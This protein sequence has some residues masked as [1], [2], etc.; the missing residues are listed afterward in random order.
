MSEARPLQGPVKPPA[1][2]AAAEMLVILLHGLGADGNDLLG[3]AP[4]W[5]PRL[6]NAEF[7]SPHAPEPCDMAPYGRQWFS[8]TSRTAEAILAG[9]ER[10]A[11]ILNEFIDYELARLGLGND[12]LALVG[13]SQGTMMSLYAG[14]RRDRPPAAIIGF[15]GSL[16]AP[17]RLAAEISVRPPVLLVH[18]DADEVVPVESLHDAVAGL[19]SAGVGVI[20]HVCA[21]MGHQIDRTGLDMGGEF[22]AAHLLGPGYDIHLSALAGAA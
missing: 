14:L 19:S 21:G 13:F 5:A 9:A 1:S 17:Q 10:A 22:L 2:G 16:V 12:R 7:S 3:L 15:S 4:Y 8:L 6:P 11:P 18:G 20:W